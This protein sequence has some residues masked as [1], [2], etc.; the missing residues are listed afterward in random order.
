MG[1]MGS[2]DLKN[3]G[4]KEIKKGTNNL[5]SLLFISSSNSNPNLTNWLY[6]RSKQGHKVF[7]LRSD[8]S[9]ISD[10]SDI[11]K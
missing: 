11:T 2:G 10:I 1:E 9:A 6:I 7:H 5:L 3:K 8:R 4:R